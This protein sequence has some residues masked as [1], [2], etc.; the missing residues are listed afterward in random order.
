MILQNIESLKVVERVIC[1]C[2]E[3]GT[4]FFRTIKN[5]KKSRKNNKKIE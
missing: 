5:I 4:D 3:C 1:K 2:D